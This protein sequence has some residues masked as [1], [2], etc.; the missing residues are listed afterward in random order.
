MVAVFRLNCRTAQRLAVTD[1]LIQ[2]LRPVWD[3]ADYPGLQHLA[4]LLQVSLV[5]H[6]EEGGIGGPALELQAQRLI[7]RL[8]MPASKGFQITGAAAAAQ[9]PQHRHQQQEPLWVAHPTAVAANSFGEGLRLLVPRV[10]RS[11]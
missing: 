1:Q 5:E 7:Q 6:I 2:S 8:P 3:L 10:K 9:D 4:E 11:S